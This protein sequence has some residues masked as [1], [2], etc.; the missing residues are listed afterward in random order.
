MI[1]CYADWS[2]DAEPVIGDTNSIPVTFQSAPDFRP[3]EV[4]LVLNNIVT[5]SGFALAC[6]AAGRLRNILST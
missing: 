5:F 2:V 4:E 1:N 6:H 3:I